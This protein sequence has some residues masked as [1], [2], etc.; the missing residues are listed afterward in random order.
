MNKYLIKIA[1]MEKEALFG[2]NFSSVA[3]IGTPHIMPV[4]AGASAVGKGAVSGRIRAQ[5]LMNK[6]KGLF[7]TWNKAYKAHIPLTQWK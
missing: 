2:F 6:H 4:G 1:E 3:K 5:E 7:D